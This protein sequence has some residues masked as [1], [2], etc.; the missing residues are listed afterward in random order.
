MAARRRVDPFSGILVAGQ[1][2]RSCL[3]IG[4]ILAIARVAV[5]WLIVYQTWTGT[6]SITFVPLVIFLFPEGALVPRGWPWTAMHAWLFSGVLTVGSFAI[7]IF[8][9]HLG[10]DRDSQSGD[11]N[12][13]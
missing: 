4:A 5:L 9:G 8:V 7:V 13:L 10:R 12:G 1:F 2:W 6:E 3:R 11:S